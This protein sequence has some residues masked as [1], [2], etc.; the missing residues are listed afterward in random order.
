MEI[1]QL[2][3]EAV[4]KLHHIDMIDMS[5]TVCCYVLMQFPRLVIPMHAS[6]R[7]V[8]VAAHNRVL[9]SKAS[10]RQTADRGQVPIVVAKCQI[11]TCCC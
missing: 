4:C 2:V 10:Q 6:I 1:L 5:V 9:P 8:S 7:H 3:F 11:L